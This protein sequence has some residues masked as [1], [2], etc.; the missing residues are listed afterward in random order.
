MSKLANLWHRIFRDLDEVRRLDEIQREVI[1]VDTWDGS[2]SA[3][4]STDAYC[5]ACLIDVNSA[6]GRDES[7]QSHCMLPV[8]REEDAANVFV[9]RAVFAASG[10]R[11]ISAIT[12][13]DDVPEDAWEADKIRAANALIRAYED[14]DQNAPD[15]LY[16][17]AGREPPSRTITVPIDEKSL[18][19]ALSS[20]NLRAAIWDILIT[21]DAEMGQDNWLVDLYFDDNQMYALVAD[22]GK[23]YRYDVSISDSAIVL[24]DRAEV[25][26]AHLPVTQS[27]TVLRQQENGRWRWF[28]VSATATLNRMGEIDSRD[29][30]DDFSRR[31]RESGNYPVRDFYHRQTPFR[32]GIAD[33]IGRHGNTLVTSGLYDENNDLAAAEIAAR[34]R[35]PDFWGDSIEFYPEGEATMTP[36]GDVEIPVYRDGEIKFIST[37]PVADAASWFTVGRVQEVKRQMNDAERTAFVRLF[38]DE[39]AADSWLEEN[40]DPVNRA[41]EESGMITRGVDG[42]ED[43]VVE[44]E[45]VEEELVED[46]VIERE[47]EIDEETVQMIGEVALDRSPQLAEL[48]TGLA[49]LTEQVTALAGSLESTVVTSNESTLT[50]SKRLDILEVDEETK[51]QEYIDDLPRRELTRVTYRPRTAKGDAGDSDSEEGASDMAS[52]ATE[53]LEK[54][55]RK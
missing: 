35:E 51:K 46:P 7:V 25:I 5:D 40:V 6:A 43:P 54:W 4:S 30:F 16:E 47:I 39:A 42:T 12:R 8:R 13:P 23:L 21:H 20:D 44:E 45:S 36:Y 50:L 28:A 37:L 14:M 19:R 33:F 15:S 24:A 52:T 27:R 22:R 2:P 10:G 34:Q 26:E 9:D 49:S 48:L 17:I 11:G 1:T 18:A 3:Y 31:C 38:D 29:L 41:I 55:P 32:V 53:T